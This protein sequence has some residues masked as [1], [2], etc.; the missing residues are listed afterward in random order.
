[1]NSFDI[2]SYLAFVKMGPYIISSVLLSF[3]QKCY[4][5]A[6]EITGSLGIFYTCC[7]ESPNPSKLAQDT[8]FLY[9][10]VFDQTIGPL[11]HI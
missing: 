6:V 1:M 11:K 5:T 7:S 9:A 4:I 3:V 2:T 10:S 8:F